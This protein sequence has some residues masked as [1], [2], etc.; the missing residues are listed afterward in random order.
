MPANEM[1]YKQR[2]AHAKTVTAFAKQDLAESLEIWK[3]DPEMIECAHADHGD[4]NHLAYLLRHVSCKVAFKHARSLDTAARD[5][6]PEDVWDAMQ[7]DADSKEIPVADQ[8]ALVEYRVRNYEEEI[9]A[10]QAKLKYARIE[11][12]KFN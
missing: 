11:L 10:M 2:I 1:T 6:I 9:E 12:A 7:E 4:Y 5:I 3:A 8:R